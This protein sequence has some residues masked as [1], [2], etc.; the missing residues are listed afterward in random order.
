MS[1]S[2]QP[3]YLDLFIRPIYEPPNSNK[4]EYYVTV[5]LLIYTI[6]SLRSRLR[7]VE[8]LFAE[9]VELDL[10]T[11]ARVQA[12]AMSEAVHGWLNKDAPFPLFI[13]LST[14][15]DRDVSPPIEIAN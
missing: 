13:N 12:E 14:V 4:Q 9:D 3:L 15:H 7:D 1:I 8:A 11:V 6:S 10:R 5:C 2:I